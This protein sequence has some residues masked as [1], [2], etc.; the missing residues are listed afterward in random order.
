MYLLRLFLPVVLR[1]M[2]SVI[3]RATRYQCNVHILLEHA[4][5]RYGD[6]KPNFEN[7]ER[8][9]A[10]PLSKSGGD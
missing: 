5:N 8:A 9:T 2:L 10:Q 1:V 3:F 6:Y 4:M 7:F